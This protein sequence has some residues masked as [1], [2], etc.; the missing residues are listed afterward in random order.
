VIIATEAF[1][2]LKLLKNPTSQQEAALS[3]FPYEYS[4]VSMHTD[5]SLMPIERS[6]WAPVNLFVSESEMKPMATIWMNKVQDEL[7]SSKVD[8]FQT[9]N[10]IR[11]IKSGHLLVAYDFTCFSF[12]S[13]KQLLRDR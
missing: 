7:K 11:T 8:V 1:S 6:N 10:P 12:S 3:S 13:R 9:W 5:P 4:T 2:A